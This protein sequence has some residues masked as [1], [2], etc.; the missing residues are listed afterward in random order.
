MRKGNLN[1]DQIIE[2]VGLKLVEKVERE[3]CDFTNRVQT[4]G[5]NAVEFSASAKFIDSEGTSR[6]LIA[7]Y[8]QDVEAV[9]EVEDMGNLNW[10]IEGYEIF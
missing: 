2:I 7:Y 8:Y 5:D 9:K 1:R 10:E 6:V 3:N 4:D